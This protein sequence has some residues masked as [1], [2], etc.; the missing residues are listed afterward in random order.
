MLDQKYILETPS[1]K[2]LSQKTI[3]CKTKHTKH[4]AK[5]G[6]TYLQLLQRLDMNLLFLS[7]IHTT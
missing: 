6:H 4:T 3:Q 1:P 2:R 5:A 7:V